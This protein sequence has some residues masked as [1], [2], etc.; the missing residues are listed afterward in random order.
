MLK[1]TIYVVGGLIKDG[2]LT[3][4]IESISIRGLTDQSDENWVERNL[5]NNELFTPRASPLVFA[6]SDTEIA[7]FGGVI[8]TTT[9]PLTRATDGVII[10]TSQTPM[11]VK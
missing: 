5:D 4:S 6:V 11:T 2:E 1:D 9:F 3:N 8:D 10:D 7:V